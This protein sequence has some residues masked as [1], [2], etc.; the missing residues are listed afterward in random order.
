MRG[1][2]RL[3][4]LAPRAE[5]LIREIPDYP[6]P[7]ILFRDIS[8]LLADAAAMRAVSAEGNVSALT[9]PVSAT[10]L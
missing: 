4:C 2:R 3:W 6:Q 9:G 10:A 8:P 1:W 7:G 5:T